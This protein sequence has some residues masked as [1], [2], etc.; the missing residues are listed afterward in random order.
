MK[1]R[2]LRSSC[3]LI[4]V[5]CAHFYGDSG[6]GWC[7]TL[8]CTGHMQKNWF[9]Q[10]RRIISNWT[11]FTDE[12]GTQQSMLPLFLF[13][14]SSRVIF[15]ALRYGLLVS[16]AICGIFARQSG[17]KTS[18]L[19]GVQFWVQALS[20]DASAVLSVGESDLPMRR[21]GGDAT[22]KCWRKC[23]DECVRLS[24]FL[25][26]SDNA[27]SSSTALLRCY[28]MRMP[29]RDF[30]LAD[31]SVFTDFVTV[32]ISLFK[33]ADQVNARDN[34]HLDLSLCHWK[35]V[36]AVLLHANAETRTDILDQCIAYFYCE[37]IG[38]I[39]LDIEVSIASEQFYTQRF[40]VCYV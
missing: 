33:C 20:A 31:H 30:T 37:V 35:N 19:T 3:W 9:I 34:M 29:G 2:C 38:R 15:Q 11:G 6:S 5:S 1:W 36:I 25:R 24:M 26:R 13:P 18:V 12:A 7:Q 17:C 10:T 22:K 8:S 16:D 23:R 39:P 32:K 27:D 21:F 28:P 40:V 4:L 14:L